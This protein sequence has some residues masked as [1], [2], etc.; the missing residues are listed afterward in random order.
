MEQNS[1]DDLG[2]STPSE[3][4]ITAES[5]QNVQSERSAASDVVKVT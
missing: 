4:V 3:L 1:K 5:I 2:P